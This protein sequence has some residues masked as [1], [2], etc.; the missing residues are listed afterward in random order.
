MPCKVRGIGRGKHA[1][2]GGWLGQQ[3]LDEESL[4]KLAVDKS[5]VSQTIVVESSVDKASCRQFDMVLLI[6]I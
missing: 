3:L 2:V 1:L 6:M 4:G 5:T